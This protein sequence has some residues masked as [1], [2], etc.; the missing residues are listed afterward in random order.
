[1]QLLFRYFF[2]HK[3]AYLVFEIVSQFLS[4]IWFV[5]YIAT[6]AAQNY[7]SLQNDK[8]MRHC[9][10]FDRSF[11]TGRFYFYLKYIFAISILNLIW[12]VFCYKITIN[13]KM[14][15]E[16]ATV[17]RL[18]DLSELWDFLSIWNTTYINIDISPIYCIVIYS[19]LKLY[20]KDVRYLHTNWDQIRNDFFWID[21]LQILVIFS[22]VR[23]HFHFSTF[24]N[25]KQSIISI[26]L[27][28]GPFVALV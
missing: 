24:M 22:L 7:Y 27:K 13:Y 21:P 23:F 6:I 16:C 3:V 14:T 19:Q 20:W 15:R 11:W 17:Y 8:E 2:L 12:E 25:L 4:R 1:M 28:L 26:L 18:I 9:V 5:R 10:S